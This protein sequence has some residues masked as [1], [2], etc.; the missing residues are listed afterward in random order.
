[1]AQ[2]SRTKEGLRNRRKVGVVLLCDER[3]FPLRWDVVPGKRSDHQVMSSMVEAIEKCPWVGDAPVVCDRAMGK[4][5]TVAGLLRSGLRFLTA[6]P[7]NEIESHTKD[8]PWQPLSGFE[9]TAKVDPSDEDV[10]DVESARADFERDVERARELA[11]AAGMEQ[12]DDTLF[13]KDLGFARRPLADDETP[14]VGPD[15]LDPEQ[16]VGVASALAWARIFRRILDTGE[17]KNQAALAQMVGVSRARITDVMNMLRLDD[18]TQ[19]DLFAGTFGHVSDQVMRKVL[20][21]GSAAAQRK[22]LEAYAEEQRANPTGRLFRP[23]KLCTTETHELRRVVY[24]NPEMFVRQLL[25]EQK[26]QRSFDELVQKINLK[27]RSPRSRRTAESIRFELY[28][29]LSREGRRQLYDITVEEQRV[30]PIAKEYF[31]AKAELKADVVERRNRYNGFVLLVS[32]RDLPHSPVQLAKLYRHKDVIERDFRLIKSE[33]ELRPLYHRRDR[34]IRAHVTLCMLALLVK[35]SLESKLESAGRPMTADACL[36]LLEGCDLNRYDQSGQM[37][38]FSAV[39]RV[40]KEQQTVMK[41]LG[42]GE[43]TDNRKVAKRL[44]PRS[45]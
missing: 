1:M 21:V 29:R 40:N 30:S 24:F 36:C 44:T 4:S 20:K 32:H 11:A 42:A 12:V 37:E 45:S 18:R 26:R 43:M 16:F 17:A 39:S 28:E 8:I 35:R 13:V 5:S 6:V 9:L 23:R 10:E 3:G 31:R 34:K 7:R 41:A 15:D 19:E 2:R 38:Q 33:V 22:A 25:R 14:W 27:A